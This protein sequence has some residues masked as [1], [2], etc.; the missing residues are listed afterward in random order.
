MS[1]ALHN[2]RVD[3]FG[4]QQIVWLW[5]FQQITMRQPTVMCKDPSVVYQ[6]F[7]Q[8]EKERTP[9]KGLMTWSVNWDEGG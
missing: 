7:E 5:G 2:G 3:T 4:Y 6:V 1:K 8:M 9:L